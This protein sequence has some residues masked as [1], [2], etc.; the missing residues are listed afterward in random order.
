MAPSQTAAAVSG[1]LVANL[2]LSGPL[3]FEALVWLEQRVHDPLLESGFKL[4]R[5]ASV[6]GGEIRPAKS[7]GRLEKKWANIDLVFAQ[8]RSGRE[9]DVS[10]CAYTYFLG[11]QG[12]TLQICVPC[13]VWRSRTS[14]QIGQFVRDLVEVCGVS[15]GWIAVTDDE[16][17][18][19]LLG[20]E[21][22][23]DPECMG[24][25]GWFTL[26][27]AG[28][29][30]ELDQARLAEFD[31]KVL[32]GPDGSEVTLIQARSGPHMDIDEI[33]RLDALIAGVRAPRTGLSKGGFRDS[34][35]A[36]SRLDRALMIPAEL[37]L[38]YR[39]PPPWQHPDYLADEDETARLHPRPPLDW[40]DDPDIGRPD[41]VKHPLEPWDGVEIQPDPFD[42]DANLN[43]GAADLHVAAEFFDLFLIGFNLGDY[44]HELDLL[45]DGL[46][47]GEED[48]TTP[49]VY[50]SEQVADIAAWYGTH[51]DDSIFAIFRDHPLKTSLDEYLA[52]EELE[53]EV[54]KQRAFLTELRQFLHGTTSEQLP[55]TI[56]WQVPAKS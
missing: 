47:E 42:P 37:E 10:F 55:I 22:L 34:W 25:Y 20:Y 23:D 13:M 39:D 45:A 26:F 18:F 28:M 49:T 15:Q 27:N 40:W 46:A 12:A 1:N 44:P 33:D 32:Y 5:H 11:F 56:T 24:G 52:S 16:H 31:P 29:A 9:V 2:F 8:Q 6:T 43:A 50:T 48:Y 14:E 36:L 41:T 3:P 4:E 17:L 21:Q 30:A 53:I 51:N 38:M 54:A 7:L 19:D 35:L